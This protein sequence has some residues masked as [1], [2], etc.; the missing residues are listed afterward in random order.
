[1]MTHLSFLSGCFPLLGFEN[2]SKELLLF[3]LQDTDLKN[4][5]DCV[6]YLLVCIDRHK[7]FLPNVNCSACIFQALEFIKAGKM[8]IELLIPK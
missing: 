2:N 6:L 5:T 1:M 8:S 7:R 4:Q 3:L